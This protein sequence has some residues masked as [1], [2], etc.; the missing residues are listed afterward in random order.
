MVDGFRGRVQCLW[1]IS[2]CILRESFVLNLISFPSQAPTD[3]L[4]SD[5]MPED[6][7]TPEEMPPPEPPE[8]S[9]EA[10]EAEK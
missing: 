6:T 9:Q 4:S 8:P 3:H 5:E 1:V 7:S 2:I 10:T